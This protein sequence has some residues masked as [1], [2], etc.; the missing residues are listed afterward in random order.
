VEILL[1]ELEKIVHSCTVYAQSVPSLC[2]LHTCCKSQA[3][4]INCIV[5]NKFPWC[6][7]HPI[8]IA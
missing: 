5:N 8:D 1:T 3:P 2:D 4:F 6:A 7:K